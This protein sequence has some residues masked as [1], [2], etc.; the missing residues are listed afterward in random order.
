MKASGIVPALTVQRTTREFTL[1]LLSARRPCP[2]RGSWRLR[3]FGDLFDDCHPRKTVPALTMRR[4]AREFA[5]TAFCTVACACESAEKLKARRRPSRMFAPRVGAQ[6]ISSSP[7]A[8]ALGPRIHNWR[9]R[10]ANRAPLQE[11]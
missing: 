4:A 2:L 9:S 6:S 10:G 11:R 7:S 3:P 8:F 5:F 1:T